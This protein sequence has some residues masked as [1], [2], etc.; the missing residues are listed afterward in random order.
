MTQALKPLFTSLKRHIPRDLGLRGIALALAFSLWFVVNS[1]Q[2]G[3]TIQLD[4]PV[5]YR[6]LPATLVIVNQ[7]PDFVRV[8][9]EG[10]RLLLSLI[11][12]DRLML[13]LKLGGVGPGETVL[14]LTPEMFHVPRQTTVTQISPSQIMLDLD[15]V[16]SRWIP[17]RVSLIGRPAAGYHVAAVKTNP[18]GLTV[19][20]PSRHLARIEYIGTSPLDVSDATSEIRQTLSLQH[21][22][23][24]V[25]FHMT[26]IVEASVTI[27]EIR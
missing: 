15:P 11:D 1:S 16:V 27:E 9:I 5:G 10:P 25:E 7:H 26:D 6:L 21:F 4:V 12:P 14:K 19:R 8:Q 18:P 23:D 24:Q 20:G 2:G 22:D 3:S 13:R 17:V